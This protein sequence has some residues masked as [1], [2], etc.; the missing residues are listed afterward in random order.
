MIIDENG[1][2]VTNPDFT[3]GYLIT[4]MRIKSD[5]TPIDDETKFAW[6]DEDYE[7]ITRYV[8]YTAEEI[9]SF[10]KEE[11]IKKTESQLNAA[12][13]M[14]ARMNAA[15]LTDEQALSISTLF[16]EWVSNAH[17]N[18]GDIRRYKE[19]LYRCL[20]AHDGQ[21]SWTPSDAHSL[22]A[23]IVEPGTIPEW[24]QPPNE[25]P[26]MKGDKVIHNGKTWISDIDNN[27]WE[28]G[29]YGWSVFK[30]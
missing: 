3:V 11:L 30:E 19:K 20:Q 24:E 12:S 22:W 16:E 23:K 13:T 18:V 27:V 17:Y 10:K 9:E 21:P 8:R 1:H 14:F 2:E 25:T 29:V 6:Y 7:T 26:F 4:D 28:P 15:N 5:A